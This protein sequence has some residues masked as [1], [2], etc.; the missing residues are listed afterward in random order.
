[1]LTGLPTGSRSSKN[2]TF[3]VTVPEPPL[4]TVAVRVWFTAG[5]AVGLTLLVVTVVVVGLTAVT[6]PVPVAVPKFWSPL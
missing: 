3:P 2:W 6:V 1:M 4:V 5:D